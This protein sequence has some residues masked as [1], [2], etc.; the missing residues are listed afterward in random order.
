MVSSGIDPDY[1]SGPDNPYL[2]AAIDTAQRAGIVVYSIYYSGAGR[3]AHAYR[4]LFWGQNYLAQLSEETGGELY[5]LGTENPVSMA[6]YLDDLS[7]RLNSQYLLTF[8]ARPENKP[9][10]Q[11]VKIGT[12]HPHVNLVGP[13]KV[14]VP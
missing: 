12:E 13:A 3:S 8:L 10:F 6:P 14:Y 9:G 7:G 11:N 5:Y 4:Q 1:G 2:N